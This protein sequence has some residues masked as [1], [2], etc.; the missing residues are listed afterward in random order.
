[1]E[2]RIVSGRF[3]RAKVLQQNDEHI[4]PQIE[5][6]TVNKGKKR[7]KHLIIFAFRKTVNT[8]TMKGQILTIITI[9]AAGLMLAGCREGGDSSPEVQA[10]L[11]A[12]RY[13]RDTTWK[14]PAF[15][16]YALGEEPVF[17]MVTTAGTIRFRFYKQTPRHREVYTKLIA[18]R[19]FD[20]VLFHRV[21]DGFM[22]QGGDPYTKDPCRSIEEWGCGDLGFWIPNEC[23]PELTHKRGCFGGA[24]EV[25]HINPAKASS[26]TQFYIVQSEDG[27]KHLNGAYTV[28][29]ETISGFEVIDAIAA[30]PTGLLRD[31]L[32]NTPVRILHIDLV[33]DGKE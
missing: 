13:E 11:E 26:S 20:G 16:P 29:A 3:P 17:D 5:F 28:F 10:V 22:I 12:Y 4:S 14:A 24:R 2:L 7:I 27:C 6:K 23:T 30:T 31:E 9:A 15:D 8:K 25:D 18:G 33:D 19:F 21:V 32:P 1:M